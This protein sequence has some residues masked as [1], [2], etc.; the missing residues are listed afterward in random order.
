MLAGGAG[1]RLGGGKA[2]RLLGGETL[3]DH[4]IRRARPQ[5]ADLWLSIHA[6]GETGPLRAIADAPAPVRRGPLAGIA[7][8]LRIARDEGYAA[9]ASFP[10]D[11]PF[12]PLDLVERL[13][14]EKGDA[15]GAVAWHGG[16]MEPVLALW[17]C[18]LVDSLA[19]HAA[20]GPV[21]LSAL[22]G[23][24]GFR[25]VAFDRENDRDAFLNINTPDDL[26]RAG[27]IL[28]HQK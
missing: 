4:V 23:Q 12:L 13:R 8:A 16:R 6:A 25:A 26:R 10:C 1:T 5:V 21:R 24:L 19:A 14:R 3:L 15:P 22:V 18:T 11:A 2:A 7:A 27:A 9:L 28:A 17:S 20:H